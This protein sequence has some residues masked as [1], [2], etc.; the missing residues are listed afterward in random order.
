M[1]SGSDAEVARKLGR[2]R[3][4]VRKRRRI[5]KVDAHLR[6]WKEWETGLLG[7]MPDKGVAKVTGRTVKAVKRKREEVRAAALHGVLLKKRRTQEASAPSRTVNGR[8]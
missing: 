7:K 6:R 5:L 4:S 2:H 1:G 8:N 3:E